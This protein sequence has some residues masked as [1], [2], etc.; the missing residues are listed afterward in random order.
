MDFFSSLA[1]VLGLAAVGGIV[2]KLLKQ[3][4]IIGY[5]LAGIVISLLHVF[6]PSDTG[7]IVSS[8][9]QIGVTLLLFL[10]GL[11][12]PLD[13]LSRM[14]KTSIVTGVSQIVFTSV[15]GFGL[16]KLLGF[17]DLTSVYLGIGLAFGSTVLVINL[18]SQK[19]DL[20]SVYG[21]IA[22][23][24]LLVQDFVAI[25]LMVILSGVVSGGFNPINL[26]WVMVKGVLLISIAAW[27][28]GKVLPKVLDW[29]G[30]STEILFIVSLGWCLAIAAIV[31]SPWIGFTVEL[32]GFLA[33][34]TLA[35]AAQNLQIIS[36]I[37]PL[38]D[39]FMTL[40]FVGLGTNIGLNGAGK[41]ILPA[42]VLSI[43]VLV[44]NPLI[45][46]NI[47]GFQGFK[48][49]ISFLAGIT[50][51]QV[52]E[53]SLIVM[54]MAAKAGQVP[55]EAVSLTAVIAL[56]TMLFSSYLILHGDKIYQLIGDKLWFMNRTGRQKTEESLDLPSGEVVLFGHN[57][58]GRI[59][60]PALEK[61]GKSVL[62]I[63]FDPQVLSE[64]KSI[65]VRGVYGDIADYDLYS[66]IDLTKSE[67]LISTVSD[68]NDNI[69]LLQFVKS[70]KK[71]RPATILLA[72]DR[73]EE[74]RLYQQGADF[75]LVPHTVG[76][77]YLMEII[78]KCGTDKTKLRNYQPA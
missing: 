31:A 76:G 26:L 55:A 9:G 30:K 8:M 72:Q 6:T 54:A 13:E 16:A 10:V 34:L 70:M 77:E 18:L 15:I 52:S 57:R 2:A 45:L 46:M 71:N 48:K 37:R 28:S 24:F 35:N 67:V 32:G 49:R 20:Q 41:L 25:G 38:R 60:R 23:G 22:V 42:L 56:V 78:K 29:F 58:I 68:I 44:G 14:G 19:K 21:R 27:V 12:L 17:A 62:V 39:F 69:Q 59:L 3:P 33:G 47:L 1:L 36:R 61:M 5:I 64:L 40:F 74:K 53:F 50:V 7:V 4:V 11:E 66:E 51:A 63:D 73:S 75:V 43:F 65:G